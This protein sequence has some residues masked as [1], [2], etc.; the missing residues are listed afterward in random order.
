MLYGEEFAV[1]SEINTKHDNL[2]GGNLSILSFKP[3]GACKQ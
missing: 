3:V 1:C 2:G